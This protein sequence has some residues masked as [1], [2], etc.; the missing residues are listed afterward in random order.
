[1]QEKESR[2]ITLIGMSGSGKSYWSKKFKKAGFTIYS[3][4]DLISEKISD[5][6]NGD[7]GDENALSFLKHF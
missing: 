1:M 3:I 4:D 5:L 2:I 7:I 6:I